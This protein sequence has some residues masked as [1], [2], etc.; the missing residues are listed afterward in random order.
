M[1]CTQISKALIDYE[2]P[3]Y[4]WLYRNINNMY[5]CVRSGSPFHAR[6]DGHE[7]DARST[8]FM[9]AQTAPFPYIHPQKN[10]YANRYDDQG[11]NVS[12]PPVPPGWSD[13]KLQIVHHDN[14]NISHYT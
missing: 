1:L 14:M 9:R 2:R 8:S 5:K 12:L 3:T 6:L 11:D 10:S 13:Q 4:Y 7:M